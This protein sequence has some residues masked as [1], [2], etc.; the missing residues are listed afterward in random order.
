MSTQ[1]SNTTTVEVR[2]P[3]EAG[4][5]CSAIACLEQGEGIHGLPCNCGLPPM[6]LTLLCRLISSTMEKERSKAA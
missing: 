2:P 4:P 6:T 3:N 1:R 5:S